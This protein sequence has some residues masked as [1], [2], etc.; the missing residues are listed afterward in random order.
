MDKHIYHGPSS[1]ARVLNKY[2]DE[3]FEGPLAC[4]YLLRRPLDRFAQ[5]EGAPFTFTAADFSG[6][7]VIVCGKTLYIAEVKHMVETLV[8]ELKTCLKDQLLFGISDLMDVDSWT[9]GTIHE[10]PRNT[11]SGYSCLS[12]PHNSTWTQEDWLL[13]IFLDHPAVAG[14]FHLICD[15]QV[16]WRAAPCLQYLQKCHEFEM[17]LFVAAHLTVGEPPR[18]TEFASHSIRNI[19]G[20]SIRNVFVLFQHLCLMGTFNKSAFTKSCIIRVPLPEIGRLWLL[21]LS[22][23]RPVVY[24]W[25]RYFDGA[26][27]A[28]RATNNLFFGFRGPVKSTDLSVALERHTSRLLG[29]S[30]NLSLWRHIVTWFLNHHAVKFHEFLSLSNRA[31]LAAQMGHSEATHGL[32]A[33]DARLPAGIDFH[34][35]FQSM[36]TSGIWHDLLGFPPVLVNRIQESANSITSFSHKHGAAPAPTNNGS[37]SDVSSVFKSAILPELSRMQSRDRA[38]D[39]A[40]L[41]HFMKT[42]GGQVASGMCKDLIGTMSVHPHRLIAL[43]RLLRDESAFFKTPQQ[44]EAVEAIASQE[45]SLLIIGPT[46]Q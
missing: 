43:R 31:V 41:L 35:C 30:I 13:K 10:E 2:L 33:A 26:P 18:G 3:E 29:I 1:A 9:P 42:E 20:G 25:Q 15:D 46:S 4:L 7:N 28:A 44:A 27:A 39:F 11:R 37:T 12:D 24:T 5:T 8:S 45:P 6:Q 40:S 34:V 16:V 22:H 17:L 19:P 21:Y 23:I 38:A 32:Y 14:R 36:K